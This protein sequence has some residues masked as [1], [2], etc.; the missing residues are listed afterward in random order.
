MAIRIRKI[1]VVEGGLPAIDSGKYVP[2]TDQTL[3][4]H[5]SLPVQYEIEGELLENIEVGK[6]VQ[7]FRTKRNGIEV[8]GMFTTSPVTS[9]NEKEFTTANS[10]YQYSFL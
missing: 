4:E 3:K 2:G 8:G 5:K 10:K 1:D 6:S 9:V 7:V